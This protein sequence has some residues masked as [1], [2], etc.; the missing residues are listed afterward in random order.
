MNR[1]GLEPATFLLMKLLKYAQRFL[2]RRV[3]HCTVFI[4]TWECTLRTKS[5]TSYIQRPPHVSELSQVLN[6][7]HIGRSLTVVPHSCFQRKASSAGLV[8]PIPHLTFH[9]D[10]LSN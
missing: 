7:V 8:P 3:F 5:H 4:D 6:V 2:I 9:A 10:T 1:S